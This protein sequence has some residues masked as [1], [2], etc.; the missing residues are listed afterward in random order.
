M[1]TFKFIVSVLLIFPFFEA[2]SQDNR[3]QQPLEVF[4]ELWNVFNDHYANF[5]LKEVNWDTVYA[6][7]RPFVNK[8]TTNDSLY[9]ICELML[10]EL[11]DGHVGLTAYKNDST[12]LREN[13]LPYSTRLLELYPSSRNVSPNIFD[14][15][16]LKDSFLVKQGFK[17]LK[18]TSYNLLAYST[19]LEYGYL[20]IRQMQGLT[21]KELTSFME[22]AILAFQDKKGIIID[23]RYNGGG[24]DLVAYQIA[25]YFVDKKR[26]GHYKRER[27][28][29]TKK[30]TGFETWYLEPKSKIGILS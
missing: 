30:Y 8:N 3:I 9:S 25:N 19:S 28:G 23:I 16:Y 6:K 13:K 18:K 15:I 29:G 22:E 21:N 7:Y 20:S 26:I 10:L 5:G 17:P 14:L 12:V 11:K 4:D 24:D 1:R 27:I 2:N